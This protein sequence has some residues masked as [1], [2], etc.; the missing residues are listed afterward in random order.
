MCNN[1]KK[2]NDMENYDGKSLK[3]WERTES[4]MS[5]WKR[6]KSVFSFLFENLTLKLNK[7]ATLI[8]MCINLVIKNW[9]NLHEM[10]IGHEMM[11]F[12]SEKAIIIWCT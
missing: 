4:K 2:N 12:P 8:R 10:Q 11:P 3:G 1:N 7:I 9:Q 6:A 5:D